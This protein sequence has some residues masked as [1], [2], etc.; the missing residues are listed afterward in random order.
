MRDY[1]EW[2]NSI[3]DGPLDLEIAFNAGRPQWISVEDC[4]PEIWIDQVLVGRDNGVIT[5]MAARFDGEHFITFDFGE[6]RIFKAPTHWMP[7]PPPPE[8]GT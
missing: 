6:R 2:I 4:L 8:E 1:K 7:L 5:S 3:S